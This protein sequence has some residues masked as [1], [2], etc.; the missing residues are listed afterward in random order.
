MRASLVSA[1][2]LLALLLAESAQGAATVSWASSTDAFGNVLVGSTVTGNTA[3]FI[4]TSG[5]ANTITVT[6]ASSPFGP[7]TAQTYAMPSTGGTNVWAGTFSFGPLTT[8][9]ATTTV[10]LYNNLGSNTATLTLT[11]TGVAPLASVTAAQSLGNILVGQTATA[12]V[13]VRNTGNGNLASGGAATSINNLLG[14]IGSSSSVF[15]GTAKTF[16]LTD[17]GSVTNTYTYAPTVRGLASQTVT[18]TLQNGANSSNA[19]GSAVTTLTATGVAPVAGLA[20]TSTQYV[21][22]GNSSTASVVLTNTGNG[23]LS[24][25]GTVSNLTGS[26]STPSSGYTGTNGNGGHVS[27]ADGQWTSWG[28][29]F[30]PTVKGATA[31]TTFTATLTNGSADGTNNAFSQTVSLSSTGVAPVASLSSTNTQ[32]VLVGSTAT[33]SVTLTNTGNGNLSGLGSVSNLNGA[34]SSPGVGYA[35]TNGS[36]GA[37]SQGDGVSSSWGGAFAPTVKGATASIL[38]KATLTNGNASGDNTATTLTASLSSTGVAAVQ[39]VTAGTLTNQVRVGTTATATTTITNT[40]NGNLSGLGSASNLNGSVAATGLGSGVTTTGGTFSLPDAASTTFGYTFTPVSR[41]SVTSTGIIAFSNGNSA[42]TNTSQTVSSVFTNQGVGPV[43][44]SGLSTTSTGAAAVTNTPTAV[45]NGSIGAASGSISFGT[46]GYN[47]SLTVYL[48]IRNTTPD[49]AAASLTN[50]TIERYSIAG[51]NA[52]SYSVSLTNG[53]VITAGGQLVVP[54]TVLGTSLYGLLNSTLTIFT[55]E[56]AALGGVGDTFTYSLT[57]LS[58]P[59]PTSLAVI[60]SGLAGLAALRRRRKPA[61]PA[62]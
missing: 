31:S 33:A 48:A 43:Y 54:I 29:T 28:G 15:V 45:A 46:V 13:T 40:G 6:G 44:S 42:G 26:H 55:D 51:L 27:L 58:V 1:T 24:G 8:G 37:V 18:T 62:G 50:L 49:V 57:A 41:G 36:G 30:T 9:A 10:K 22:V 19:A 39:S 20:S 21:L 7:T 17:S 59:E 35:G 56:S 47:K 53:A 11:G 14:T 4:E 23:N 52:S 34:V 5:P 12:T 2:S 3:Q 38:Y 32:Y 61:A 60:G 16:A 25:L